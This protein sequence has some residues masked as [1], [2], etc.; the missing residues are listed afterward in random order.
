MLNHETHACHSLTFPPQYSQYST[1]GATV[2]T[3][4]AALKTP[5]KPVAGIPADQAAPA[6]PPAVPPPAAPPADAHISG[7]PPPP[8]QRIIAREERVEYRDQDGNLLDPEVAR[9][10]EGKVEFRTEYE[11]RTRLIDEAGT[12]AQPNLH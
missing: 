5:A 7:A 2:P 12:G 1:T 11:V 9:A 8:D 6:A 4:A 10:L 3:S